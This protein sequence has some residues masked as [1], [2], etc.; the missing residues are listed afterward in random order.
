MW[1]LPG[2]QVG[3]LP[4]QHRPWRRASVPRFLSA[5]A[6]SASHLPGPDW[7]LLCSFAAPPTPACLPLGTEQGRAD[8]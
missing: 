5:P 4:S 2:S 1:G 3:A 8:H 6:A 7:Y